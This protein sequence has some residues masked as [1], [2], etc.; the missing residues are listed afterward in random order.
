MRIN[1]PIPQ[2]SPQIRLTHYHISPTKQPDL[3]RT[4]FL[5]CL[6]DDTEDYYRQIQTYLADNQLDGQAQ[7]APLPIQTWFTRHGFDAKLWRAAQQIST[8]TPLLCLY[9]KEEGGQHGQNVESYLNQHSVHFTPFTEFIAPTV[10]PDEVRSSFFAD[11]EGLG[12]Y[13]YILNQA[14]HKKEKEKEEEREEKEK[15]PQNPPHFYAVV[16][17]AKAVSFPSRLESAGRL[18]NLYTGKVG[19]MLEDQAPYLLEFDPYQQE[20]VAFLQRLFRKSDSKVFSHWAIN[21]VI[22]IKSRKSF[23]E[24]YHHLRKWTH[25]YDPKA[26][27][28]YFFRFYDPL[29]LNRYL[30]QLTHY[31]A[32]LAALFGVKTNIKENGQAEKDDTAPTSP[33]QE[34]II[35]AFGLRVED[36]FICFNLNPL[37]ENT[38]PAKIELGEV[39]R[40]AFERSKW[41]NTK[42]TLK[43]MALDYFDEVDLDI[44]DKWLEEAK[45]RNIAQSQREYWFYLVGRLIAENNEL[46]YFTLL[47]ELWQKTQFSTTNLLETLMNNL[48]EKENKDEK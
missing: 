35:E 32:Q 47:E 34:Q 12:E 1:D 15:Q 22:F 10:L 13:H 45:S 17:C 46:N 5:L 44:I 8:S 43:N 4:A 29:V 21:P 6:A 41:L 11:F 31:P 2:T 28:W 42:S 39:E 48:I 25:L 3:T 37:P 14:A 20:T 19:Q 24:V 38:Q 9:T 40:N 36:E 23:D 26:E 16:D 33:T 30:P 18:E 7:L 27:K